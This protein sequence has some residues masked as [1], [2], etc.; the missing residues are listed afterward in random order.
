MLSMMQQPS[1]ILLFILYYIL[2]ILTPSFADMSLDNF[3]NGTNDTKLTYDTS[4]KDTPFQLDSP[5]NIDDLKLVV[6]INFIMVF[7]NTIGC[8]Y[9]FYRSWLQW[10]ISS[11][12]LSMIF[13]LPFYTAIADVGIDI[14]GIL[15]VT[16][17]AI[18]ARVWDQPMCSILSVLYFF[19]ITINLALY[20]TVSMTTYLRVCRQ[21]YFDLG[22]FDYK[23]WLVI[24]AI[25]AIFQ[26]IAGP[27]YGARKYWCAAQANNII[28]PIVC[29]TLISL[30][31]LLVIFCYI[32]ILKT[33]LGHAMEFQID[34]NNIDEKD[35]KVKNN[36]PGSELARTRSRLEKRVSN[37]IIS[38]V[39]VFILQWTP[40]QIFCAAKFFDIDSAW[41]YVVCVIGKILILFVF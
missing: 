7:F 10:K 36:N 6:I 33:L 14:V 4:N 5:E 17:T 16:H 15:N 41:I 40:V 39:L 26:L 8:S 38:Y 30:I 32:S 31:F 27:Y 37:K 3:I 18:N 28:I 21:F 20:G 12:S 9:V 35:V 29:F 1:K 22:K 19:F 24:L 11:K 13:R 34:E 25:T 2:M 23:L